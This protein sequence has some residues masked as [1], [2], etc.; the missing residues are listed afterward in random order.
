MKNCFYPADILLPNFAGDA[1]KMNRWSCV[2]CDQYTS[3]PEYWNAVE[4]TVGDAPSTLRITLPELYLSEAAE[5]IPAINAKMRDYTA[6]I[7]T[8]RKSAIISNGSASLP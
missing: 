7:L 4:K 1:E 3:E 8:E 2:A 6:S 5:R